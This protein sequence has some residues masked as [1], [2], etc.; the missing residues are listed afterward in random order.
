ML[1]ASDRYVFFAGQRELAPGTGTEHFQGLLTMAKRCRLTWLKTN[2]SDTAHWEPMRGTVRQALAYCTKIESRKPE[3]EPITWGDQPDNAQGKRN[4]LNAVKLLIDSGA[5]ET[6]LAEEFFAPWVMH[7]RGF[8]EYKRMKI[9]PRDWKTEVWVIIGPTGTG[10]SRMANEH[11]PVDQ[12][13]YKQAHSDWWDGYDG[14]P[15][16]VLD[17]FYGW[18]RFDEMLRLMDRYPMLVQTKGG[19]TQMLCK[20][21]LIT[22]NTLPRSWYPKVAASTARFD[23]FYRRVTKWIYLGTD[24]ASTAV[25]T[26]E[27]FEAFLETQDYIVQ[28]SQ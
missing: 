21:L 10:K 4:D 25:S 15:T 22:S 24:H 17:D 19:Q 11:S 23:A 16:V 7:Y 13:Y 9:T 12:T 2:V 1:D 18:I 14:Q 28:L 26:Y 6:Q 27:D 5:T 8:R 3:Y 20:T